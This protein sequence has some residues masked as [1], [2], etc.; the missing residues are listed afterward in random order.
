LGALPNKIVGVK[1]TP[2]FR[3]FPTFS[4]ISPQRSERYHQTMDASLRDGEKWYIW[5]TNKYV[6]ATHSHPPCG[7]RYSNS[8]ILYLTGVTAVAV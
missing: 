2:K 7:R 3:D 5:P 1:V 4:L 8:F 6:I